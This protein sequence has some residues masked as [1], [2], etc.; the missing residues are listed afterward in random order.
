MKITQNEQT[1]LGDTLQLV[2]NAK[3]DVQSSSW[4]STDHGKDSFIID[5]ENSTSDSG[6]ITIYHAPKTG[7]TAAPVFTEIIKIGSDGAIL[8][9]E[10]PS[11]LTITE[12]NRLATFA[13]NY[14]GRSVGVNKDNN[15]ESYS[16]Q[17]MGFTRIWRQDTAPTNAKV[18]DIWVDTSGS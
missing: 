13:Q 17:S 12:T 9:K 10:Q 6:T 4:K 2:Q 15:D 14:A 7:S 3:W 1:T 5:L 11:P 18:W 8:Y 16:L